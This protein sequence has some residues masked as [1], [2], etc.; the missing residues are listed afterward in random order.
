MPE[1]NNKVALI[2]GGSSGIGR[3]TAVAFARQGA[4]VV[5]S[6][7]RVEAGE[8]TVALVKEAGSEGIFVQTDVT[9]ATEVENLINQ[10]VQAYGRI[11]YAF[12]NA[13]V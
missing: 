10:A 2:T 3:A 12:N 8:K 4:K 5:V 9:Q 7:R 6:S 1:M 13:G 11:D